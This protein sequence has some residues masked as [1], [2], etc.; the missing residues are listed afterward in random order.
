MG[1]VSFNC[2]K[3]AKELGFN[4][5]CIDSFDHNEQPINRYNID[6]DDVITIDDLREHMEL[7]NSELNDVKR[8]IK[9]TARPTAADLIEWIRN[10]FN[11][12]IWVETMEVIEP[13]VF[14][15]K[16][17]SPYNDLIEYEFDHDSNKTFDDV[18]E[19]MIENALTTI[20]NEIYKSKE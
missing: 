3:L 1:L 13:K 12:H 19:L 10:T 11:Y 16:I 17:R 9:F 14:R 5:T 18:T 2:A 7:C 6:I 20:K 4:E 15:G 8:I